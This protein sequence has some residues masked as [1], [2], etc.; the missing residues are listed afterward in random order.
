[1]TGVKSDFGDS[2]VTRLATIHYLPGSKSYIKT[3]HRLKLFVII[4][5]KTD[6][7]RNI[8]ITVS[9]TISFNLSNY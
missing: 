2:V 1:M 8:K 3:I 9:V 7:N 5:I 4:E 6:R